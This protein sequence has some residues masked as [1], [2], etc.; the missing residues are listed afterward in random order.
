MNDDT[1]AV[2]RGRDRVEKITE[3]PECN[4]KHLAQDYDRGELVCEECGLVVDDQYVDEGPESSRRRHTRCSRNRA[5]R[6]Q[7]PL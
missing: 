3:C 5:E 7:V 1:E 2:G 4:S 6:V